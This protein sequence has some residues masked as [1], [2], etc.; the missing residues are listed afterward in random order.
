MKAFILS[1]G[2]GTRLGPLTATKPKALVEVNGKSMLEN[3]VLHLKNQ[4]IQQFLINVHHY[5]E[6]LIQF[7]KDKNSFGVDI[8]FSD[9]SLQLLDTGGAIQKAAGFF[10]G[11]ETVLI[12]NVDVVSGVKLKELAGCHKQRKALV[13]LCLRK[14]NSG[15]ALL[16]DEKMAL[17]GWTHLGKKEFKWVGP[18]QSNFNSFA[19]SGICL[20]QPG[21]AE[22][23]PFTGRFSVIDAWLTMAQTERILG[24]EDKSDYWFDLGTEEK[25]ASAENYFLK[26]GN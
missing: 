3:L 19:Y 24:F 26:A 8:R 15:R 7:V 21:F 5:A 22:K 13:T 25:I 18:P 20:A 6:Q 4:G 10:E 17:T 16:F 11:N 9:E 23:L 2:L 1:A 12:H 14:R